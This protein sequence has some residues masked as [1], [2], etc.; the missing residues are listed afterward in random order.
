MERERNFD[1]ALRAGYERLSAWSDLLDRINVFPVAD[2]DTGTNL[3][4]SLAPFLRPADTPSEQIKNLLSAATGNS[5]NIASA[6]FAEFIKA[7]HPGDLPG[8]IAAA[9]EKAFQAVVD[10]QPG[11]M[12][13]V[14][15]A[16]AQIVSNGGWPQGAPDCP[17]IVMHLEKAVGATTDMLPVLKQAGVIDAGA[18]GMFIFLETYFNFLFADTPE[19]RSV[20]DIFPGRLS[21]AEDWIPGDPDS[22]HCINTLIHSDAGPE[23]V[24]KAIAGYGHSVVLS[25]DG[26]RIKV[27]LHTDD[28]DR[29][30]QRLQSVGQVA[31]WSAEPMAI[32]NGPGSDSD[33]VHI[34]SDAAGSITREDARALGIT[35]LDSYL[36]VGDQVCPE[37]M[38]QPEKLYAA[39]AG[40]TKVATAQA[41]LF[42]R[43][44]SYLS[45]TQLHD[46]VL[47][48][49]V[50]S[51][52]TGNY[53]TARAWRAEADHKNRLAVIDTGAASG[54]LG[55]AVMAT[56]TFARTGAAPED[57]QAF[58][59]KAVDTS[60]EFVFL[61][62]LKYLAA[63]GRISK[64]K[65]FFGDLLNVKPVISPM[66]GGAEKVAV[67]RN[68]REQLAFA[69]D[70]LA[71][72]FTS[73]AEFTILVQYSD[74]R[75]WVEEAAVSKITAGFP[76]AKILLRPLSLTSGAH[77]GPGTWAV[78][79]LPSLTDRESVL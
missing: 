1:N 16:L 6:F 42:E 56:A 4:V 11:T 27:H 10:P 28:G 66:P 22:D 76:R 20:M 47:Y 71:E 49:C 44:Q 73:Q 13:T 69:L 35:L 64:T 68:G 30:H 77:M 40:G 8:L 48:L 52:Y 12:L 55:I 25:S 31:Q 78:A 50:G 70:R 18:L 29:L 7:R 46:K 39:M 54:R 79:F 5:G 58:A 41:S 65:G 3:K 37:T 38:V 19:I 24:R 62:Q 33:A 63:G 51:V 74:N 32:R 45:A 9:R 15:D 72:D 61:D 23:E 36:I 2:S 43:R 14:F 26:D 67:V 59:R 34:M 53:G 60:R 21:L 75:P 57:V 17:A